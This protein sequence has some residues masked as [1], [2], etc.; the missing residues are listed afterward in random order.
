MIINGPNLNFLGIREPDVY[1]KQSLDDLKVLTEKKL[2][3]RGVKLTWVQS[4]VEGEIVN[5]LQQAFHEKFDGV[6]LNPGAYAHTSVAIHDAIKSISLPVVE[7]HLSN[8]NQREDFRST[9]I[10]AKACVAVLEGLGQSAYTMGV[11]TLIERKG[12]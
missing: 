10:T 4:N 2:L 8:T 1:G 3:D 7:V 6:V 12:S 5:F 11:L 9:K